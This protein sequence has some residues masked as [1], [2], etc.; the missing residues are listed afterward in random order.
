MIMTIEIIVGKSVGAI[1]YYCEDIK[2]VPH[3]SHIFM[4][5]RCGDPLSHIALYIRCAWNLHDRA[6]GVSK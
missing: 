6:C 5:K 3:R 2:E 4:V 1:F